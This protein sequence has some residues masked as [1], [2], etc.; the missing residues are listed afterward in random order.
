MR[1]ITLKINGELCSKSNSRRIVTRGKYPR[2]IKSE[3]ALMFEAS[4]LLQISQQLKDHKPFDSYVGIEIHVWYASRRPDL[5]V[6]LIQDILEKAKIY[7]NDRQ[8]AEIKALKYLDKNNPRVIAK[9]YEL[10]K[11]EIN[12]S[13]L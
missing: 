3:K 1:E 9:I 12:A 7:K 4:A 10:T 2:I 13:G 11:K 8:V 5:D 6:S